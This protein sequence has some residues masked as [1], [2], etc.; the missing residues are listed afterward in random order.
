MALL[1]GSYLTAICAEPGNRGG[2]N[3]QA[4]YDSGPNQDADLEHDV[5]PM[6]VGRFDNATVTTVATG[7]IPHRYP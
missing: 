5:P 1:T 7:T 2:P 3:S 4:Q 6:L